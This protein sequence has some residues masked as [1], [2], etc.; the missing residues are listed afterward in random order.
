M[1]LFRIASP[2]PHST[3]GTVAVGAT[4]VLAATTAAWAQ[5]ATVGEAGRT[6]VYFSL[7]NTFVFLFVA[8]GPLKVIG[9]FSQMTRGQ[10][11]PFKRHLAFT[12]IIIAAIATLAARSEEHT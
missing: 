4:A 5:G 10:D 2:R 1:G 12:S 9:P 8:L 3:C 7:G 6:E 11:G